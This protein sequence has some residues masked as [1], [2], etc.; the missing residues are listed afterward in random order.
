VARVCQYELTSLNAHDHESLQLRH[1]AH[2]AFRAAVRQ[3]VEDGTF[4]AV[5]V[6]RVARAMLS[7]ASIWSAGVDAKAPT[8]PEQLGRF[9]ADLA[10]KMVT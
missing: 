1:R 10:L 8:P 7:L 5:D 9:N 6:D 4:A 2:V 3:G